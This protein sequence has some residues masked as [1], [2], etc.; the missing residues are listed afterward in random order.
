MPNLAA[1]ADRALTAMQA[2]HLA[3]LNMAAAAVMVATMA[4]DGVFTPAEAVQAL[5]D[6]AVKYHARLAEIDGGRT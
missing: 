2:Y 1:R 5:A 3:H 4:T 6:F